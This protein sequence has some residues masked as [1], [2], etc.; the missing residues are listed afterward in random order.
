MDETGFWIGVI[1]IS[2]LVVTRKEVK[3][4]YMANPMDQTLVTS[5]ECVSTDRRTIPPLAI[6]LQKGVYTV[7]L[8]KPDA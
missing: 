2:S 4:V 6:L 3:K 7:V 5:V 8:S 1:H